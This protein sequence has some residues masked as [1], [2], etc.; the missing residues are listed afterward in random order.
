MK[1]YTMQNIK[2]TL[3][4]YNVTDKALKDL[5]KNWRKDYNGED[6]PENIFFIVLYTY[7]F[8]MSWSRATSYYYERVKKRRLAD[9]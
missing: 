3:K 4:R 1:Y 5:L 8:G 7:I 2:E 6:I 9:D